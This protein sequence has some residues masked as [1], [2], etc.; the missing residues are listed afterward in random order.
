MLKGRL[1]TTCTGQAEVG[2]SCVDGEGS[3][4]LD[5]SS[6]CLKTSVGC[7]EFA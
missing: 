6:M 1:E 4:A 2:G 3:L 5:S 7:A